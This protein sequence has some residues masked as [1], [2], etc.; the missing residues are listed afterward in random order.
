MSDLDRFQTL[1]SKMAEYSLS[2]IAASFN[3]VSD[4]SS[5]LL[6][7]HASNALLMMFSIGTSFPDLSSTMGPGHSP[8]LLHFSGFLDKKSAIMFDFPGR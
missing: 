6:L 3:M 2:H 5:Y 1:A 4:G 8:L 7:A